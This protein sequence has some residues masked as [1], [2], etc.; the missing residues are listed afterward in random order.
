MLAITVISHQVIAGPTHTGLLLLIVDI[1]HT[2]ATL[3]DN[4]EDTINGNTTR[5]ATPAMTAIL[6][7]KGIN[8]DF[9]NQVK[10]K[11]EYVYIPT[12]S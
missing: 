3:T 1:V 4:M 6:K 8:L 5:H 9:L 2:T 7:T 12:C 10:K 11:L